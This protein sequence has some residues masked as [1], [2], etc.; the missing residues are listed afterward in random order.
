MKKLFL[1]LVCVGLCACATMVNLDN[2][3]KNLELGMS[4]KDA[5]KVL[6]NEY[7]IE[8]KSIM[9]EGE[10][11]VLRFYSSYS[12]DY[13]LRFL[14][15]GLFEFHKY[16]APVQQEVRVIKEDEPRKP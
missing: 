5:V 11:E 9:S 14:N 8:V 3:V 7:V 1:L 4:R 2:R 12:N 13:V 15:G 16:I 10:M 6:G